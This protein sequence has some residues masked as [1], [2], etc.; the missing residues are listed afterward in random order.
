MAI[1]TAH[2]LFMA[3]VRGEKFGFKRIGETDTFDIT[4]K[5][6]PMKVIVPWDMHLVSS[7][8]KM[9]MPIAANGRKNKHRQ[10]ALHR[11]ANAIR[12]TPTK[13]PYHVTLIR[14]GPRELDEDDNLRHA[15]KHVK[16]GVCD[17]LGIKN[18]NDKSK[19][20]WAYA[21]EKSRYAAIRIEIEAKC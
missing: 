18:D 6:S 5:A 12:T 4:P 1:W 15:F 17:A 9:E 13:P 21:Q 8:N 11:V 20:T 3:K 19:I 2:Q 14:I 10:G 7:A 16:D